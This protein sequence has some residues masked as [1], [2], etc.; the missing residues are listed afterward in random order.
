MKS[1]MIC[2]LVLLA[3]CM[4]TLAEERLVLQMKDVH[5]QGQNEIKLKQELK[6]QHRVDPSDLLLEKVIVFA[7][8]R[9]GNGHVTLTV[10]SDRSLREV[11]DGRP[12]DFQDNNI[13]TYS[14]IVL[15]NPAR[16]SA[17]AWQLELQGNIKIK[18]IALVVER[19][20]PTPIS[21][22][23]LLKEFQV[24]KFFES[25][26]E[27]EVHG[28][29]VTSLRLEADRADVSV[30]EVRV[31]F[32]NGEVVRARELEGN[33]KE[34]RSKE[35]TLHNARNIKAIK[36]TAVSNNITGSRGTLKL[37]AKVLE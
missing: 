27:I 20:K 21:R 12:Y 9:Q 30:K 11:V 24:S 34:G 18:R 4:N 17:G 16:N 29:R 22:V 6:E 15:E 8:S 37:E 33:L 10:G 7:K 2:A 14:K 31:L 28:Q 25:S 23:K 1:V 26:E 3:T 5:L 32:G 36:V 35:L 13:D 19:K